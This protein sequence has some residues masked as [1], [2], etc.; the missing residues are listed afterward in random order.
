MGVLLLDALVYRFASAGF[1]EVGRAWA[2]EIGYRGFV[3]QGVGALFGA[4]RW[5]VCALGRGARGKLFF[6]RLGFFLLFLLAL[7]FFAETLFVRVLR[8]TLFHCQICLG[9]AMKA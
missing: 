3:A 2:L 9:H 6:I 5:C 8:V 7:L 1:G 4:A